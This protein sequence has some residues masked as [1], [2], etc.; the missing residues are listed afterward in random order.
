MSNHDE[1][2]EAENKKFR[3]L[4][5]RVLGQSALPKSKLSRINFVRR[6]AVLHAEI[7][8]ALNTGKEGEG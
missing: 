2:A 3:E 4:L 7:R 1:A 6:F 5:T 8:V